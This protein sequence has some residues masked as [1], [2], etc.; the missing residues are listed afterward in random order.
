MR[1]SVVTDGLTKR[2]IDVLSASLL[3]VGLLLI[4][5]STV[6]LFGL[7]DGT[8]VE[9]KGYCSTFVFMFLLYVLGWAMLATMLCLNIL[10]Y[11]CNRCYFDDTS[12]YEKMLDKVKDEIKNI[13]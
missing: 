10:V 3:L 6:V 4:A 9:C 1:C 13:D 7:D 12:Y 11:G 5:S 8:S 2:Q